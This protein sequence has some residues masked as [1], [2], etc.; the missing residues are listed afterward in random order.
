[1]IQQQVDNILRH[2]KEVH[3]IDKHL[4]MEALL[5]KGTP[6]PPPP[7]PLPGTECMS[8]S[9][10]FNIIFLILQMSV[11]DMQKYLREN[12]DP[13]GNLWCHCRGCA[14]TYTP[15]RVNTWG[16]RNTESNKEDGRE[17]VPQQVNNILCHLQKT[18]GMSVDCIY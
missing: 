3:N 2:L 12:A 9:G 15:Y 1:M 17:K 4:V 16:L 11:K 5:L 18:H 6:P 13:H 7:P 10:Q 8:C 14:G